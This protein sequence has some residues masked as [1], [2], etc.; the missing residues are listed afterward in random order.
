MPMNQ[1][2]F[3]L[4][5]MNPKYMKSNPIAGMNAVLKSN[6]YPIVQDSVSK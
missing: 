3:I 4:G 5:S 2:L 1:F 6:A